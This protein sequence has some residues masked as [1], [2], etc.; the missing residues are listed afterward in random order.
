MSTEGQADPVRVPGGPR[1]IDRRG[2]RLLAALLITV[3]VTG[4]LWLAL[5][6]P[7]L[8][9]DDADIARVYGRNVAAGHGPVYTPGFERVEGYSSPG[10][11]L[12]WAA[13]YRLPGEPVAWIAALSLLLCSACV[14]VLLTVV[15]GLTRGRAA[16]MLAILVLATVPGFFAWNT[17]TL[18]DLPL[19]SALIALFVG[20]Q[21]RLLLGARPAGRGWDLAL[22]LGLLVWAR[23]EGLALSPIFW[24]L[25]F[26]A[27]STSSDARHA[28]RNHLFP[29]ATVVLSLAGL[30]G[31]RLLIFGHPLPNTY[32]AKVSGDWLYNLSRGLE[33]SID[34]LRSPWMAVFGPL[35]LALLLFAL[36][37]AGRRRNTGGAPLFA[38]LCA[39]IALI[40]LGLPLIEGGDHFGAHRLLQPFLLPAAIPAFYLLE[41]LRRRLPREERQELWPPAFVSGVVVLAAMAFAWAEFSLTSN[42]SREFAIAQH[43][44]D[45]GLALNAATD[46]GQRPRVGV[47]TAGGV[48]LNY[49][50]R[51]V[52]LMGLNWTE[53]AH[54]E[55]NRYGAKNHAAFH[56]DVFWTDAPEL[57][58]PCLLAE[59]PGPDQLPVNDFGAEVLRGLLD[60]PRFR[61]E[62]ELRS[63]PYPGGFVFAYAR[64]DWSGAIAQR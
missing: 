21:A 23:P 11:M 44:R 58:V 50:G 34:F 1:W 35:S 8:G 2:W 3:L 41:Q 27:A 64:R 16:W 26:A 24:M 4:A 12:A 28:L 22:V 46:P 55:G 29:L 59:A 47:I 5:G 63:L 6:S 39:A 61:E 36:T 30:L 10:W 20:I 17:L 52:D 53:M 51:V 43:G 7:A 56:L 40:G 13:A 31:A 42:L 62:Y 38:T 45:L 54:S 19:W 14:A 15:A 37:P 9:I 33:Y 49:D 48:A 32:Y 25:S 57:V 60:T 18:M